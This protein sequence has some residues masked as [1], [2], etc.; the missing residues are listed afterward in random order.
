MYSLFWIILGRRL[1]KLSIWPR[2]RGISRTDGLKRTISF[3]IKYWRFLPRRVK[4]V[5]NGGGIRGGMKNER[6]ETYEIPEG[7]ASKF[8]RRINIF[9]VHDEYVHPSPSTKRR[10]SSEARGWFVSASLDFLFCL[11][12]EQNAASIGNSHKCLLTLF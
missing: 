8:L 4:V 10:K 5:K 9:T 3:E 7:K 11:L 1:F 6:H 2:Q 12:G